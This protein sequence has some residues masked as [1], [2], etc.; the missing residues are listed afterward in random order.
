MATGVRYFP[1]EGGIQMPIKREKLEA[2]SK[3]ETKVAR[4]AVGTD[5]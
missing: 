5:S 1:A 2:A 4:E 3:R